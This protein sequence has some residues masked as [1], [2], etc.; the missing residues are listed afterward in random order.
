[1]MRTRANCCWTTAFFLALAVG[2]GQPAPPPDLP[3]LFSCTLRLLQDGEPLANAVVTL[4]PEDNV[5]WSVGGFSNENG[6]AEL[7]TQGKFPGV[8]EGSYRVC[9]SK[10]LFTQEPLP[11]DDPGARVQESPPV[12]TVAKR[13][14]LP[15]TTSITIEVPSAG[16]IP[17][18]PFEVDLGVAVD[19]AVKLPR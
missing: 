12:E 19:D 4:F 14:R 8:P 17:G 2:C 13:F 15:E 11:P 10:Q 5:T 1:M 18:E 7:R 9:V 6:L 3:Q 16:S